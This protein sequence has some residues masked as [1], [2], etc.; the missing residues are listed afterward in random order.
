[1]ESKTI[2][3]LAGGEADES[4]AG[5]EMA[6]EPLLAL[7]RRDLVSAFGQWL[8]SLGKHPATLARQ[9]AA[10]TVD[11]CSAALG[12][13]PEPQRGDR[14]FSD[15][16]WTENPFYRRLLGTYLATARWNRS[17]LEDAP[18]DDETREKARVVVNFLIEAVAPTNQFATNPAAIK[19]AFDTGGMSLL[20]GAFNLWRDLFDNHGMPAQADRSAF[21]LGRDI[22]ATPGAVVHR[23]EI[24]ELIQF[25]PATPT[26]Y[27][28]PILLC[29]SQVNRYYWSDLS[30]GRSLIK[31]MVSRG[32]RMFAMSWRNPTADFGCWGFDAYLEGYLEA[33]DVVKEISGVDALH[34][35]GGCGGGVLTAMLL[36]HQRAIG[37]QLPPTATYFV[38]AFIADE[39]SS[40]M[41]V[42]MGDDSRRQAAPPLHRQKPVIE[43]HEL[44]LAFALLRPNEGIWN[45]YV[46]NYLLGLDPPAF[47]ILYWN[48][49]PTRLPI[50][51]QQEMVEVFSSRGLATPSAMSALGTPVDLSSVAVESFYTAGLTDHICPWQD[52]YRSAKAFGGPGEFVLARS[53]HLGALVAPPGGRAEFRHAPTDAADP[54]SWLDG[55]M[56]VAGSW[57]EHWSTWLGARSGPLRRVGNQLGSDNHRVLESAP[58]TYVRE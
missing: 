22:A 57:W 51:L 13:G 33:I 39:P 17:L 41:Q 9:Y 30:S 3:D 27:E 47:D 2:D 15:P 14:R 29:P 56:P 40:P 37:E 1:V 12:L 35:A 26:V 11:H 52:C 45:F 16:A 18:I 6:L 46:N 4:I 24:L 8:L 44:Q 34:V 5:L 19:R 49:F 54:G 58:G 42:F 36:A 43:G 20:R 10:T 53:G 21:E 38:T 48:S 50:A 7:D 31:Y 55:A 32:H 28:T 23:N 25:A